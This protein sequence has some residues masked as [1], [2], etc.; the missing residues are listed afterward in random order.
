MEASR[1]AGLRTRLAAR[2]APGS[3]VVVALAP[4]RVNLIGE[5]VDYNDGWVLPL[6]IDRHVAVAA[7]ARGDGRLVLHG[8]ESTQ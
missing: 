3:R 2:L 8:A 7:A 5:H 4:G 6:A 1:T